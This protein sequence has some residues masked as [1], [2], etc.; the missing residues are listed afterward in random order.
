MLLL[1]TDKNLSK[2]AL[3]KLGIIIANNINVQT[4]EKGLCSRDNMKSIIIQFNLMYILCV[5]Y[6][7]YMSALYTV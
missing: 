1:T 5:H 4:V 6:V 7:H 2:P 3:N